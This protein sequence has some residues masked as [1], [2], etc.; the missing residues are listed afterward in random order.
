MKQDGTVVAWGAGQVGANYFPD[1]GQSVV[2]A[3]L[4]NVVAIAA[5]GYNSMALRS[6]GSVVAWGER[7]DAPGGLTNVTVIGAGEGHLYAQRPGWETPVVV[8]QPRTQ[9]VLSGQTTN[10]TASG[11]GPSTVWYQWQ[12][13]GIPIPGATTTSL[14]VTNVQSA[15][16]GDYRILVSNGAGSTL[17]QDAT[18]NIVGPPL[19][20]S[21]TPQTP[22][23]LPYGSNF[24]L[25][26]T[27][28]QRWGCPYPI[29]YRWTLNGNFLY[30]TN[31]TNYTITWSTN[32]SAGLYSV[33]ITN[34]VGSNNVTFSVDV[35]GEGHA[36]YW[37]NMA[38]R[39]II[40]QA[41]LMLWAWRAVETMAFSFKIAEPFEAGGLTH[42][43]KPMSPRG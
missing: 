41:Y 25:S 31:G 22:V 38:R 10:F 42:T 43:D 37:G 23:L 30:S 17:S 35:A 39:G 14:S 26:G 29:A 2:P 3:G 32:G 15:N 20:A 33:S 8:V 9:C 13:H 28:H 16:Q 24:V 27:G 7:G 21:Q 5:G 34:A 12:F 40:S 19:I 36:V 11:L 1:M 4:S 18:L 6:D